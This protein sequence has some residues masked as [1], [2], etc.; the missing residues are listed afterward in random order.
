MKLIFLIFTLLVFTSCTSVSEKECATMNWYKRGAE[1]AKKG[2]PPSTY[3]NY[4]ETCLR[5]GIS[6]DPEEY[7]QGYESIQ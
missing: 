2:L 4:K 1:D 5:F 6:F 3:G 7:I